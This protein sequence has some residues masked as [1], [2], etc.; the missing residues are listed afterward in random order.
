[1]G[2]SL[3]SVD[4]HS[5][6]RIDHAALCRPGSVILVS[7]TRQHAEI[8][9]PDQQGRLAGKVIRVLLDLIGYHRLSDPFRFRLRD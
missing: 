4:P 9:F 5:R 3:L 7:Y 2:Q 1:M 6:V 8:R